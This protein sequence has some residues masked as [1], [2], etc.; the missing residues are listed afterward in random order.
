MEQA[1]GASSLDLTETRVFDAPLERVWRAWSEAGDVQQWWGPHGF[2]V[3]VVEMDF[4]EGGSSFVCMQAPEARGGALYCNTWTYRTIAPHARIEFVL[5]FTDEARNRLDP[6]AIP[7]MPPG[8]PAG[9]PH[10]ITFRELEG[11]RTEM[12]IVETGY[13]T[14]AAHN[15]SKAGLQQ[16][17]EKLT[18][19]VA[20]AGR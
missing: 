10:E 19:W 5:H 2:T 16:V 11:E 1:Q 20:D 15:Q 4:R 6:A 18:A 7:G 9:V 17:L 13:T 8:I 12:T 14:E 3:P